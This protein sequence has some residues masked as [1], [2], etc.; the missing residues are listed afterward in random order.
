[1][2]WIDFVLKT[3]HSKISSRRNFVE[4]IFERIALS[5]QHEDIKVMEYCRSDRRFFQDWNMTLVMDREINLRG[6]GF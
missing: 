4:E 5:R 6:S 3:E 1:M 2:T